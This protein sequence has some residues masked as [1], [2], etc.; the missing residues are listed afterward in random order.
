MQIKSS[1]TA[2]AGVEQALPVEQGRVEFERDR[3]V[4]LGV[5]G[6]GEREVFEVGVVDP[7]YT[8]EPSASRS[9][10]DGTAGSQPRRAS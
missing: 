4:V 3:V 10:H 7:R 6:E 9:V 8:A 1:V 2:S 5:G